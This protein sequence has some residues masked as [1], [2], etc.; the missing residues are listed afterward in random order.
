M[1]QTSICT[2]LYVRLKRVVVAQRHTPTKGREGERI[3]LKE[4]DYGTI[5][6]YIPFS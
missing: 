3:N 5:L 4:D 6:F 2:E 1:L